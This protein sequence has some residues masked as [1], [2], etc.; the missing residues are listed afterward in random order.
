MK[1]IQGGGKTTDKHLDEEANF[2]PPEN[3]QE[4]ARKKQA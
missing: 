4:N 1:Q 3:D 2:G